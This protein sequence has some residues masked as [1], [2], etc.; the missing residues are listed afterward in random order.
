MLNF[1][2]RLLKPRNETE[3][4]NSSKDLECD[5]FVLEGERWISLSDG[6][7]VVEFSNAAKTGYSLTIKCDAESVSEIF[8]LE[9]ILN[10]TRFVD[11]EGNHCFQWIIK[12][13]K[14][15]DNLDEFGI[16][17]ETEA[18]ASEFALQVSTLGQ[19]SATIIGEFTEGVDLVERSADDKWETIEKNVVVVISKT[20]RGDHFLTIQSAD[21]E[22]MFNSLISEALQL[23][24]SHPPFITFL[25]ITPLSEDLRVLGL[26]CET[27]FKDLTACL[28]S[29]PG[30]RPPSANSRRKASPPSKP[31]P[32]IESSS[33]SE[34]DVEMWEADDDEKP[35]K[36]GTA[37]SRRRR[38]AAAESESYNRFLETG[39]KDESMAVVISRLSKGGTGF[40]V[41]NTEGGGSKPAP[42]SSMTKLGSM[43]DPSAVMMH[44]GDSKC[45]LLDPSLGRDKV[46]ELDLERGKIVNEWTPGTG[47]NKMMPVSKQSQRGGEKTF[48]G[49]NERSI[50]AIDPRMKPNEHTGNRVYSFTYATNVKLS[51]AATD[52][53]G[54]IVAGNRSGQLRLFDG[55][56]NKEGELK[57]A[58]TLL[59]NLS[60]SEVPITHVDVTADGKWIIATCANFL[61]L[62]STDGGSGFTKS[63]SSSSSPPIILS[64]SPSD[65]A[66]HGLTAIQFTGAK[67]DEQ[68]GLIVTS[69]GSLAILWDFAKATAGRTNAY[70]IKPMKDYIVDIGNVGGRTS[71]SVVAMYED[72]LELAH[73]AP[74]RSN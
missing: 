13:G 3:S 68:R 66:K 64:L 52:R 31:A 43:I 4:R 60:T 72:R 47:I 16:R 42:I 51:T 48:L 21:G 29:V 23:N 39:H 55:Q 54:H 12:K 11:E 6:K 24:L 34:S 41:F 26:E 9:T 36:K 20:K 44:E 37:V 19:Q 40:Q 50:F 45:L 7:C 18:A 10:L 73:V 32:I 22:V 49:M 27:S 2:R 38:A 8:D 35:I 67:F 69:T 62:V 56:T 71:S 59:S 28:Q 5:F 25:G 15:G 65:I 33:S 53:E 14:S 17:F 57:R 61:M 1:A 30:V 63:I 74:K 70:S 46:F 58:K